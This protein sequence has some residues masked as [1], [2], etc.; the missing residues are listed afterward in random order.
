MTGHDHDGCEQVFR[1]LFP[2]FDRELSAVEM[3]EVQRH[4]ADCPPCEEVFQFEGNVLRHVREQAP[5]DCCPA[6]AVE[7][8]VQGFR[9]RVQAR[10]AR[11]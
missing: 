9:A 1:N 8:I 6:K 11:Q 10:F 4:L 5:R 2:Y 3:A 7:R